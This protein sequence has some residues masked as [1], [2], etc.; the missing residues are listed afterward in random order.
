MKILNFS[1]Q[2]PCLAKFCFLVMAQDFAN[3]SGFIKVEYL[4]NDLNYA[5]DFFSMIG[6]L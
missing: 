1:L 3:Q 2:I 6:H 4:K 5:F